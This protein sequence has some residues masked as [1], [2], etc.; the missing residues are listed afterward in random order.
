MKLNIPIIS[1][2]GNNTANDCGPACVAMLAGVTI[3]KVM[4]AVAHPPGEMM[5]LAKIMRALGA[6]RLHHEHSTALSPALL[7]ESLA[8]GWPVI[9][10][11]GYGALP[12]TLKAD[13]RYNLNHY[14]VISGFYDSGFYVHDPLWP[15]D[16]GSW[17]EW[18]ETALCEALA[19]AAAYSINQG[20]IV[21]SEREILAPTV[22]EFGQVANE[23]L[24]NIVLLGYLSD[25][26]RALGIVAGNINARQGLALAEIVRLKRK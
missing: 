19:G 17:R 7:R 3:D 16:L 5:P 8:R 12:A 25:I 20:V 4:T 18:P 1:Q 14:V 26:Y 13:T 6:Y 10:L 24:S 23:S 11:V 2:Q 9:A 21:R 15:S 22:A